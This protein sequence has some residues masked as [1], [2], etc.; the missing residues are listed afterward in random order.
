MSEDGRTAGLR[1]VVGWVL[2]HF[3]GPGAE[4]LRAQLPS[5]VIE[6]GRVDT[7]ADL[8]VPEEV[9]R[10]AV[11]DGPLPI[12]VLVNGDSGEPEGEILVWVHGG[13]LSAAEHAWFT[14][15]APATWPPLA[16]LTVH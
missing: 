5:A 8:V 9:P 7:F 14:D 2:D 4:A 16:R 1:D 3:G 6:P 11:E 12:G 10:A 13:R 15:E